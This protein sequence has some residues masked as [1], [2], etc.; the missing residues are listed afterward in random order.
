MMKELCIL[1]Y[2]IKDSLFCSWR[3]G[4]HLSE[5]HG[6]D[7]SHLQNYFLFIHLRQQ[8]DPHFML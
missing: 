8:L 3:K 1:I 6:R 5:C 7:R 2:K 4:V